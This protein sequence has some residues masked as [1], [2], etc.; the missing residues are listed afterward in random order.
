M[1]C[2]S[3]GPKQQWAQMKLVRFNKTKCRVLH[4]GHVNRCYQYKLE[5]VMMEHSPDR[6]DL[7]VLVNGKL[8]MSQQCA[9]TA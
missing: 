6:K 1:G 3:E 2:H 7:Q 4:L 5:D 8:N 9:L